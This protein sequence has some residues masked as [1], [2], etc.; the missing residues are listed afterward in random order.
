MPTGPQIILALKVAV[1]AVTVLLLASL[2]ALARGHYR[3]HGRINTAF[4]ILTV[5]ALLSLEM[6]VRVLQPNVFEY[7]DE[8]TRQALNLHLCFSLPAAGVM[9]AMLWTGWTR[10]RDWHLFLAGVF[11]VLWTGT[12]IT[13]VFFLPH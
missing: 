13:G 4:F 5:A 10:R 8:P 6:S 12:V 3:L 1:I 9:A 11:T 2:V 7:F